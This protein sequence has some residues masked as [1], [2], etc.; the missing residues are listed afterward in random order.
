MKIGEALDIAIQIASAL[1]AA[2]RLG[3]VHR[4]I[5]PEN[6]MLRQDGLIKVLDFGLAKLTERKTVESEAATLVNTRLGIVMGTVHYM[7][8]EQARGL[9]VDQRTDIFSLGIVLY[10]MLTGRIPFEGPTPSDVI[11]SILDKEPLP[12]SQFATDIPVGLEGITCKAL[13]KDREGRY[14]TAEELLADLKSLK[15]QIEF[16]AELESSLSSETSTDRTQPGTKLSASDQTFPQLAG[17]T[18]AV[19]AIV[20]STRQNLF[21]RIREPKLQAIT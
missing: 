18:A 2:H 9:G 21:A 15:R 19:P 10:E 1:A 16:K 8:P 4:D 11:V 13:R 20:T 6:V 14:Q 3:I 7:S 17:N 5:K 12:L